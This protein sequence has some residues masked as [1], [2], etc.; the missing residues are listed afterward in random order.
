VRITTFP[1]CWGS[2]GV[3]RIVGGLTECAR[4][5]LHV[6]SAQCGDDLSRCQIERRCLVGIDPDSHRV[7][8]SAEQARVAHSIQPGDAVANLRERVVGDVPAIERMVGRDEVH[9]HQEVG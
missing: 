4:R 9:D 6:L 3:A 8:A 2:E 7:I 5:H 1:N